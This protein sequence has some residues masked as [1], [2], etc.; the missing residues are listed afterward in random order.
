MTQLLSIFLN[1]L[2]PVFALVSVGYVV[3]PRLQLEVRTLSRL[4][5]FVLT[6]VFVFNVLSQTRI[7]A[8][9]A[10]RMIGFITLVYVGT[11]VLAFV[12]ARLL[13]RSPQ[14]TAAYVMIA[15]FGNV[16]NFG[17][18]ITQFAEGPEALGVATVFF[19]ANL[20]LA[21]VVCVTA[22]NFSRGFS[23]SIVWQVFRTPALLALPPA[24][25]VNWAEWDVPTVVARPLDLLSG[26]LI[27]V[28]LLVL[29]T[30]LAAAGIPKLSSDLLIS[31]AVRMLGGPLIAFATV[32]W[33]ALPELE[34]NVG[35][36][37]ASMPT[38]VLVSI[39]AMENRLLPEFI[40]AT[41]LFSNALS[42]T[43]LA[44]VLLLL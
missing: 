9:L 36:L 38:A 17:L 1:V 27:P 29:G 14:M 21:F 40:T 12:V 30:Q 3:G 44:V 4:A 18:P 10:G 5:Y 8:A 31:S 37:Q 22:A 23:L 42:I 28:M 43:T 13:R 33:F 26:A 11:I 35:I 19:L 24:I 25:L 32:G 7:E 34:R 41:V 39:I 15:A 2:V 16:G 6:P 20:V